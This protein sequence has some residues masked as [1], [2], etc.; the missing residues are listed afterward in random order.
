VEV[1]NINSFKFMEKAVKME[2]VRQREILKSGN[3]P[4]QENRGFKEGEKDTVSQRSKEEAKDYRYFPEPDIPPI[5]FDNKYL[6]DIRK[7]LPELPHQTKKYLI[8]KY[9]L[10]KNIAKVLV[11]NLGLSYVRKFKELVEK[12]LDAGKTANLLINRLELRDLE[13]SEILSKLNEKSSEKDKEISSV[14]LEKLEEVVLKVLGQNNKAVEDYKKGK[15]AS[16]QFLIGMVMREAGVRL[17]PLT[18]KK[19]LIEKIELQ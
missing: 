19:I 9:N 10:P 8:E 5:E 14:D 16:L 4:T 3:T 13:A 18:V 11:E 12:G 1:K 15:E 17:D 6:E 2:I 7:K